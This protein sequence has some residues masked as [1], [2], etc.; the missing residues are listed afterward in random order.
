MTRI[1]GIA[2]IILFAWERNQIPDSNGNQFCPSLIEPHNRD[3][4]N[5]SSPT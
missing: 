5:Q 2:E 4:T 3:H 1:T